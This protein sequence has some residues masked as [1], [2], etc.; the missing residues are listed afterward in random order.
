MSTPPS[1]PQTVEQAPPPEASSQQPSSQAGKFEDF[2]SNSIG[3]ALKE[4][5]RMP[6]YEKDGTPEP[7]AQE[8]AQ[9]EES[10][11]ATAKA[12]AGANGDLPTPP[13]EQSPLIPDFSK[14]AFGE[15]I[16][17]PSTETPIPEKKPEPA[18]PTPDQFPEKLPGKATPQVEQAFQSMRKANKA[19]YDQNASLVTKVKD[20]ESRIK[21]FDGKTPMDKDEFA[22]ITTERDTVVSELRLS[23]LEATPEYKK[24]ITE[25]WNGIEHEIKRLSNKYSLHEH[26]V[27]RA[28]TEA[29]PDKQSE[30]LGA[31][32]ESFNDRD[33]LNLFKMADA[34]VEIARKRK[35]LHDDVQQALQYIDAKRMQDAETKATAFKQEWSSSLTKAWDTVGE[36][37]YLARPIEGNDEWNNSLAEAKQIVANTDLTKLPPVDQAKIMVQAA[38]LPRACIAIAQLWNMYSQAANALKRYQGVTPGAGSGGSGAGTEPVGPAPGEELGFIDAVEARM[39]R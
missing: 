39:R 34:A 31:V 16:S 23:K 22:R 8:P 14:L 7:P 15:K 28:I 32:T 6:S 1:S 26:Q 13:L 38:I 36:S 9:A 17:V 35:V 30:L 4:N 21:E 25:P 5:P 18:V 12:G 27:R 10:T 33:K 20:L 11:T 29:D 3:A 24:A 37:L 19:L 2:L